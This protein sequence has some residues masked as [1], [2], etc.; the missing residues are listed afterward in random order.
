MPLAMRS[1]MS[2]R[3]VGGLSVQPIA[4]RMLQQELKYK[5]IYLNRKAK[6]YRNRVLTETKLKLVLIY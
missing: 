5:L 3:T 4:L 1:L 2:G 6:Y